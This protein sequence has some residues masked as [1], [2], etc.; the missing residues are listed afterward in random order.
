[1]HVK[2][3]RDGFDIFRK[4]THNIKSRLSK[5]FKICFLTYNSLS[6]A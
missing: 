4:P 6:K 3:K 2:Y 1:M 5:V